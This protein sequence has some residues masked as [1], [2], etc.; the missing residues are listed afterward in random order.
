[1]P[2]HAGSVATQ[3]EDVGDSGERQRA[4]DVRKEVVGMRGMLDPYGR[5]QLVLVD[6]ENDR[7]GGGRGELGAGNGLDLVGEAGMD[8]PDLV[9]CGV[10]GGEPVLAMLSRRSPVWAVSDVEERLTTV[11]PRTG[12]G[13]GVRLRQARRG[14]LRLRVRPGEHRPYAGPVERGAPVRVCVGP[15]CQDGR[16]SGR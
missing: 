15:G 9:E 10:S 6:H 5:R 14:E 13:S 1:M 2:V 4:V 7:H 8:E 16:N 12:N 11:V 3:F